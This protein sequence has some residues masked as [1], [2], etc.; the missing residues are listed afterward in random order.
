MI[1]Q[2]VARTSEPAIN[3]L[4]GE[5]LRRMHP[6]WRRHLYVEATGVLEGHPALRPDISAR[7][8][9]KPS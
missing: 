4:L 3:A 6:Q 9:R 7:L 5:A 8:E 1:Q 2:Y